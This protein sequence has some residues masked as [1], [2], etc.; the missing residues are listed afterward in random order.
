MIVPITRA[1]KTLLGEV[2][3]EV[4]L[5]THTSMAGELSNDAPTSQESV[6]FPDIK[7]LFA[8]SQ[9]PIARM[10]LPNH[11]KKILPSVEQDASRSKGQA[12]LEVKPMNEFS[13]IS[14]RRDAKGSRKGEAAIRKMHSTNDGTAS[15]HEAPKPTKKNEFSAL[16][17]SNTPVNPATPSPQGTSDITAAA[18]A[19]CSTTTISKRLPVTP[20]KSQSI[21]ATKYEFPNN[22][23]TIPTRHGKVSKKRTTLQIY[24]PKTSRRKLMEDGM[25][26]LPKEEYGLEVIE[27][28]RKQLKQ[29]ERC[30]LSQEKLLTE[31]KRQRELNSSGGKKRGGSAE[32]DKERRRSKK[33]KR[34]VSEGVLRKDSG[35]AKA[36][37]SD[38]PAGN[39]STSGNATGST[40]QGPH[41]PAQTSNGNGSTVQRPPQGLAED[42]RSGD[43]TSI[44]EKAQ[45]RTLNII[46][47]SH[48]GGQAAQKLDQTFA[49]NTCRGKTRE[50]GRISKLQPSRSSPMR[51]TR[52]LQGLGMNFS[53]NTV[54]S[55]RG[56]IWKSDDSPRRTS[57]P[58]QNTP[59]PS[60]QTSMTIPIEASKSHAQH[61]PG[62][63][64]VSMGNTPLTNP[65]SQA[66]SS[67]AIRQTR[68]EVVMPD[69]RPQCGCDSL[70]SYFQKA[71]F[72]EPKLKDFPGCKAEFLAHAEQVAKCEAHSKI[73]RRGCQ[74]ILEKENQ[75][76]TVG[77]KLLVSEGE[78]ANILTVGSGAER[79]QRQWFDGR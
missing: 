40:R 46:R 5:S 78:F 44:R 65:K 22:T 68:R 56:D 61:R 47:P 54:A 26:E 14:A 30:L 45:L 31:Q 39:G 53:V 24:T 49:R 52:I 74:Q 43:A 75:L 33:K 50:S 12:T 51:K 6:E 36:A 63:H 37:G 55:D 35:D 70:H 20:Q 62:I 11:E 27:S 16:L 41:E 34:R 8:Q 48:E 72:F 32:I 2:L 67:W 79:I 66:D 69:N 57:P 28:T 29:M 71:L 21:T 23:P 25:L 7:T 76:S 18:M 15:P 77:V 10:V 9:I 13:T 19:K 73:L 17:P 4:P 3:I 1:G 64:G 60:F 38:T 42:L 58:F 59:R